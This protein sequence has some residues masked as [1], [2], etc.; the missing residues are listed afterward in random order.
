[1]ACLVA[2]KCARFIGIPSVPEPAIN[3][4]K[5]THLGW[6]TNRRC[7]T[8]AARAVLHQLHRFGLSFTSFGEF[9]ERLE[10]IL[11]EPGWKFFL[12]A[13]LRRGGILGMCTLGAKIH[14]C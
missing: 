10:E 2:L 8:S 11:E 3:I 1:M 4:R 7:S 5:R 6:R 14:G 9:A 12:V 13:S